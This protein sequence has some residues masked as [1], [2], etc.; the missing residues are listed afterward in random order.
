[1]FL[2]VNFQGAG[3]LASKPV[4]GH[5]LRRNNSAFTGFQSGSDFFD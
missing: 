1:M 4:L 2:G 3:D 5:F